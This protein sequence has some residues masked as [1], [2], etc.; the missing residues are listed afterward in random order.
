M[1]GT[2]TGLT[3]AEAVAEGAYILQ[4][5][6]VWKR[7]ATG[8]IHIPAFR[9][10]IVAT[11][12]APARLTSTV[13]D[14]TAIDTIRT[15]DQDGTERWYDMNGHRIAQPTKKGVYIYNNKKVIKK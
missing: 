6:N 8:D 10:Y 15:I 1:K 2:Q 3:N 7:V 9:A 5:G 12:A 4:S 11:G 14:A 13:G